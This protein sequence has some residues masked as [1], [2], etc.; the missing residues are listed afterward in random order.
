MKNL[1]ALAAAA[2]LALA[3]CATV[4]APPVTVMGLAFTMPPEPYASAGLA[5]LP[6]IAM[7]VMSDRNVRR[8]CADDYACAV[9]TSDG[10]CTIVLAGAVWQNADIIEHEAA[11]CVGWPADHA[12]G[13]AIVTLIG[14]AR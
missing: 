11:H 1:A 13:H 12:G 14:G 2:S 6:R 5:A 10:V 7:T 9:M 8:I 3:G 4:S